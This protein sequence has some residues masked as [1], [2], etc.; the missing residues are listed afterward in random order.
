MVSSSRV[1]TKGEFV[2]GVFLREEQ[3]SCQP[4][5]P[6]QPN[7]FAMLVTAT[8]ITKRRV[9]SSSYRVSRD[10]AFLLSPFSKNQTETPHLRSKAQASP[11]NNLVPLPPRRPNI[12]NPLPRMHLGPIDIIANERIRILIL[13]QVS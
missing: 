2:R 3:S 1:C 7:S 4:S 10:S 6:I 12:L 9:R 11:S 13:L 5:K 8:F